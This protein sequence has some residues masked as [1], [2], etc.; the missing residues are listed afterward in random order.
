MIDTISKVKE[1]VRNSGLVGSTTKAVSVA[2]LYDFMA[3][4]AD[5]HSASLNAEKIELERRLEIAKTALEF[6]ADPDDWFKPQ[7]C[8]DYLHGHAGHI[9]PKNKWGFNY[10][11]DGHVKAAEALTAMED[12]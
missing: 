7:F 9:C 2:T 10:K 5:E 12:K 3:A 8:N 11:G 4:F 1:F 6:Y